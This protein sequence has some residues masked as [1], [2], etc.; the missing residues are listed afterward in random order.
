MVTSRFPGPDLAIPDFDP[1]G[2]TVSLPVSGVGSVS[3]VT[4]SV[5]GSDCKTAPGLRHTFVGDLVGTLAGPDGTVVTLFDRTGGIGDDYC[6]AVFSDAAAQPISTATSEDAPFTGSWQP[7]EPLSAFI[8]RLGDG[9][10]RF[11]VADL[12]RGDLGVIHDVAVH[13][14]GY[15][16]PPG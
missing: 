1:A 15:E 9:T 5:D 12:S 2:S 6:Q 13:V 7:A 4:F 3:R 8:G 14:S 10:W 16:A 11:T